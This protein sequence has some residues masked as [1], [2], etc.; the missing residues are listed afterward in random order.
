MR[1]ERRRQEQGVGRGGRRG[2]CTME[3]EWPVLTEWSHSGCGVVR[4]WLPKTWS[5]KKKG[6][7]VAVKILVAEALVAAGFAEF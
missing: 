2:G 5:P 6:H 3:R 7:A 1:G 4:K